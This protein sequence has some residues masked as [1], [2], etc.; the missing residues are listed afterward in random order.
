MKGDN[1]FLIVIVEINY[2]F[3]TY[4]KYNKLFI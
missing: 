3:L 2:K 1:D 4:N